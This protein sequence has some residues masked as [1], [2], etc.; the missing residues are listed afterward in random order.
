MNRIIV[1]L[2]PS[3]Q[4]PPGP[5]LARY[6]AYLEDWYGF[7]VAVKTAE[8]AVLKDSPGIWPHWPIE[9]L[10][11]MPMVVWVRKDSELLNKA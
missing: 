5:R 9:R 4:L 7:L 1:K 11:D 10:E 8:F 3:N 6:R 2:P